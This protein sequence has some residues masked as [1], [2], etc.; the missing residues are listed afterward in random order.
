ML[1]DLRRSI[2]SEGMA[3][4]PI[5]TRAFYLKGY[6]L[7]PDVVFDVGVHDGTPWLYKSF[8]DARF[9][10]VDPQ[11]DCGEAVRASGKLKE[12]DF[13]AVAL[14]ATTGN[15]TLNIPLTEPG[16]GGAMASLLDRTD[17]L[18]TTFTAVEK[19]EV[20]IMPLDDL[21]VDYDGRVG[22]KIDTEGFETA[23]LQGATETLKRCDFVILELS[24]TERFDGIQPPSSAISLLAQAGLELRDILAI[25][26]G[27]GKRARPRH[28]DVMFTR[29]VA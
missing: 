19:L 3:V 4:H 2:R 9:V 12:F 21:A 10:L 5:K 20:P 14:G 6:G 26:D 28:M 16:K 25:A 27:P 24:V 7:A 17:R 18:A 22:V 15:A 8:P 11:P 29:W 1:A 23:V 13:H